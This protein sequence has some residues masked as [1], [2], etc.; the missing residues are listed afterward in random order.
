MTLSNVI[1]TGTLQR[2][3]PVCRSSSWDTARLFPR[4]RKCGSEV[5]VLEVPEVKAGDR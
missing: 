2:A 4:C 1:M 3:C 5:T